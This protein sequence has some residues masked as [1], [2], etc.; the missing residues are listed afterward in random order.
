MCTS[1][2]S[3]M[4][5]CVLYRPPSAP[6]DDFQA[7]LSALDGYTDGK[8]NYDLCL[9]G[10]FNFPGLT[11]DPPMSQTATPSSDLLEAFINT[12]LLSQYILQP[13]RQG[14]I[15]DL[16]FSNSSSL[17]THVDV[18]PTRMSDHDIIEIYLSYN[19]CQPNINAPPLFDA[20]SFRG[21][22]FGKADFTAISAE[23]ETTDWVE[24]LE[25]C[26]VEGFPDSFRNSLLSICQKHCPP[27]LPPRRQ[28]SRILRILSRKKRRLQAQLNKAKIPDKPPVRGYTTSNSNS[29]LEWRKDPTLLEV[30]GGQDI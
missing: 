7:C 14:N 27:K 5:I 16:F 11:W 20:A 21:L 6:L 17:V 30:W 8:D 23:I 28:S 3:K 10:D 19:P 29:L 22:N 4:I 1:E 15:L 9:L 25:T 12:H 26:G 24:K 2:P 13:T 18:Q